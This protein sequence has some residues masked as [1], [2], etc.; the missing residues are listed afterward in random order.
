M[1]DNSKKSRQQV[2][3]LVVQIGRKAGDGL[4]DGATGAGLVVFASGVDESEAVRETVAI[5]KQADTAPLDVTGYGT[6]EERLAEGQEIDVDERA[7]MD[8]ALAENA[9]IIAQMEP[10]FDAPDSLK[11]DKGAARKRP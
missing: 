5:L 2:Y 6:L 4:P 8:R 1:G 10:F 11:T 9:V 7:L 3:T